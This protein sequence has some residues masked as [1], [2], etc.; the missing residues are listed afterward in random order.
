MEQFQQYHKQ[1]EDIRQEIVSKIEDILTIEI[2]EITLDHLNYLQT[3]IT[4]EKRVLKH[5]MI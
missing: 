1:N 4:V 2:P 5:R 3:L